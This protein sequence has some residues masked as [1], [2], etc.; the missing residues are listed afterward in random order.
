MPTTQ[1][2]ESFYQQ[3]MSW[4][5]ENL[6]R[7]M[8]HFNIFRREEFA[9]SKAKPLPYSRR[10][11]YKIS[12]IIGKNHFH[13]ADKSVEIEKNALVFSNP[14]VPY[15]CEN[16]EDEQ[17]GFFCIF[18][19]AFINQNSSARLQDFPVFKPGGQPIF[20]LDD[21]GVEKVKEIFN[22]MIAEIGS[23]Y[24]YKYDALRNYVFELIHSA[25]KLTSVTTVYQHANASTRISTLFVELLE[26]Q[27]PVES[28]SRQ[29]KLR[30]ASDFA[31][32]LSIHVNHLNRALKEVTG[33]TTT[34]LIAERVLQEA[35]ALLKHTDW[36]ISEVAYGLGFE[37]PAHFNNFFKKHTRLKPKE[38]R[39]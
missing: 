2:L 20:I 1:S 35:K 32:Q 16:L 6:Q 9:G 27:F 17:S 7:E 8:G 24:I 39:V 29:V 36:N 15:Q 11:F 28:P 10:D 33:K 21:D 4:I 25:Q 30:K 34:V 37:E 31:G 13:Y 22:R 12:L 19:E 3:K 26:R 23:E 14:L 18:T 38:F 5:P